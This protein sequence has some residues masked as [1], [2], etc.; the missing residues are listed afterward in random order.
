MKPEMEKYT[1]LIS[2]VT[3]KILLVGQKGTQ[4]YQE[5]LVKAL[6]HYYNAKLLIVD[7]N[8]LDH[9][10]E[11]EVPN[12]QKYSKKGRSKYVKSLYKKE[13]KKYGKLK[14]S[15][16][17]G[18]VIMLDDYKVELC[19]DPISRG[20]EFSDGDGDNNAEQDPDILSIETLFET[21]LSTE[22]HPCILFL[23]GLDKSILHHTER[24]KKLKQ[25]LEKINGRVVVIAS[26]VTDIRKDKSNLLLKGSQNTLL[27]L[28]FLDNV[29]RIEDKKESKLSKLFPTKLSI[30]PPSNQEDLLKWQKKIEED[31]QNMKEQINTQTLNKIMEKNNIK[32]ENIRVDLFKKKLLT[33]S[34]LEKILGFS[35]S[36]F[37]MQH[38][39]NEETIFLTNDHFEKSLNLFESSLPPQT[40]SVFDIETESEYEKRLLSDVI[41]PNEINIKFDD[42]GAL[43]KVKETLKELVMLPLQRP[44]LFRKGNLKKN[45][46]KGSFYLDLLE[47]E[48]QC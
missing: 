4:L 48:K 8:T 21:V 33:R 18:K 15:Q 47:Q 25:E 43:D 22:N 9:L 44:E 32:C 10:I 27:G 7:N 16:L 36:E 45:H 31:V 40:K 46:A 38:P 37:V 3:R 1:L 11:D 29:P 14:H 26:S 35:I 42:I 19:I 39:Q 24:Y 13:K 5:A 23:K 41:P 20:I 12:K 6:A 2:S 34:Q 17:G 30:Y 28:S